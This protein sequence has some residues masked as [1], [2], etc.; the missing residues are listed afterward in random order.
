MESV[1]YC[2]EHRIAPLINNLLRRLVAQKPQGDA[3]VCD[4]LIAMLEEAPAGTLYTLPPAP[5]MR[6]SQAAASAVPSSHEASAENVAQGDE[7]ATGV[8]Y[9]MGYVCDAFDVAAAGEAP[10][11]QTLVPM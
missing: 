1:L 10:R 6:R 7:T 4:C 2:R 5:P 3:A 11:R 8:A 9:L